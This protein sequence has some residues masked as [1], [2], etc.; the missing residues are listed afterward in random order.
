MTVTQTDLDDVA[1]GEAMRLMGVST[2]KGS[3]RGPAACVTR[4]KWL[5][6]GR[7]G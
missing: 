2:K 4:I 3:Q 6:A 1:L 5:E 7:T